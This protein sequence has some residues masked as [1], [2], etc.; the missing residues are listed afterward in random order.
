[1]RNRS[2]SSTTTTPLTLIHSQL[3]AQFP[4]RLP[5]RIPSSLSVS[6]PK[7]R[8]NVLA[9][10][11][12]TLSPRR[13]TANSYTS[14]GSAGKETRGASVDVKELGAVLTKASIDPA[15]RAHA[16]WKSFFL[17]RIDDLE[18]ARVER[19]I[20]RARSD[21]TMHLAAV[22]V[23]PP[24][25]TQLLPASESLG[26]VQD[27][28][29]GTDMS[30]L[31]DDFVKPPQASLF[32]A[33]PAPTSVELD[34]SSL[35]KQDGIDVEGAEETR[36]GASV[37]MEEAPALDDSP[38]AENGDEEE[39]TLQPSSAL[40]DSSPNLEHPPLDSVVDDRPSTPPSAPVSSAPVSP[41]S[42]RLSPKQKRS[43]LQ[44]P[45]ADIGMSHT[46]SRSMSDLAS[47]A[48]SVKKPEAVNIDSFEVLRVLGKG[49][50][51]KVLLVK[52]K[53]VGTVLALKAITKR[54][55]RLP[56]SLSLLF[57]PLR[58]SSS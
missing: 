39:P 55:V 37:V 5:P 4:G 48:G 46:L 14:F 40:T 58:L 7:K 22:E 43:S 17:A 47:S 15:I 33:G 38:P 3:Q 21:A 28:S 24:L 31:T 8:N 42:A 54:H 16:A 41:T 23:P 52:E 19:R 51:G 45:P 49:C 11:T 53:R 30:A 6:T 56:S 36:R 13:N 29:T 35:P 1:V 44:P 32:D 18:S 25:P 2:L 34:S 50:A 20:K 9:S 12:R 27:A 10:L 57:L 26:H